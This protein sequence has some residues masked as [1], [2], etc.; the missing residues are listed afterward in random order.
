MLECLFVEGDIFW[1]A[2]CPD[3][4]VFPFVLR[5]KTYVLDYRSP[6]P[7]E[8]ENE[9]GMG[10]LTKLSV[11]IERISL[12]YAR[13]ITVTSSKLLPRV[14][15]IGKPIYVIPNFPLKSFKQITIA[16]EQFRRNY[17]VEQDEKIVLFI[18]KLSYVEGVDLLPEIISNV[19]KQDQN[20][21][22]WIVG[23]GPLRFL[24]ERLEH[25]YPNN[26]KFFGWKNY[27][28]I[29]NFINSSDVC[30]IPRHASPFSSFYNEEGLQKV[31]EYMLFKKP[32]IACG[33]ASSKEYL[34]V[35]E[36]E[37]AKGI[38]KA[39]KGDAPLP[40]AKTWE[41]YSEKNILAMFQML[42][43]KSS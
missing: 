15:S 27:K 34:L 25:K 29:P 4:L 7:I 30:I 31:S 43:L 2:N 8:V 38:L 18:G 3:V 14:Q 26:V 37:M 12:R 33:I 17:G 42:N 6:W 1:I 5:R 28:E 40:N 41:V 16:R 23:D 9:I 32:I 36:H 19:V 24:I 35:K 21:I 20:I 11:V 39:L 22:F 10:L 13:V